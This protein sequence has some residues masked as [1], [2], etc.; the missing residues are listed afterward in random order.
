[1]IAVML[2]VHRLPTWLIGNIT[3]IGP[4]KIIF[5]TVAPSESPLHVFFF[6][7]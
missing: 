3:N 2:L 7:E 6:F 1:M 4:I 5:Y